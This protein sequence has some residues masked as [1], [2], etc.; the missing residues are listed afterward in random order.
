MDRKD[1]PIGIQEPHAERMCN[2]TPCSSQGF[3][4]FVYTPGGEVPHF[5]HHQAHLHPSGR[6]ICQGIYDT[7]TQMPVFK[8][9]AGYGKPLTRHVQA[10]SQVGDGTLNSSK[11]GLVI[12]HGISFLLVLSVQLPDCQ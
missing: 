7:V 2:I 3:L 6:T 4:Y 5:N 12:V 10:V 11:K 8:D 9:H 1:A